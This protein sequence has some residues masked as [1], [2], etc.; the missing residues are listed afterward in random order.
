[1]VRA[2]RGNAYDVIRGLLW[3][4]LLA[5]FILYVT[6]Y[7][8]LAGALTLIR[9]VTPSIIFICGSI[10][11]FSHD[12]SIIR[13]RRIRN[14]EYESV[15]LTYW[16]ALINDVLAFLTAAAILALPGLLEAHGLDFIDLLQAALA[17]LAIIYIRNYY[18]S[19]IGR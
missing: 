15:T 7:R 4:N 11:I 18:F 12:K 8:H 9:N 10:L 17:F 13:R 2:M 16:D 14:E 1:M 6:Y 3:V 5:G 19:K